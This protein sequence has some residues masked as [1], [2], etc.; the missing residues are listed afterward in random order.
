M[1][2]GGNHLHI[3]CY[4]A[5]AD[6][7]FRSLEGHCWTMRQWCMEEARKGQSFLRKLTM[8]VYWFCVCAR[9]TELT[10]ELP[11]FKWIYRLWR[12]LIAHRLKDIHEPQ[13]ILTAKDQCNFKSH[14]FRHWIGLDPCSVMLEKTVSS[15]H[16][17]VS[18][19]L[20]LRCFYMPPNCPFQGL[21]DLSN[22]KISKNT[23]VY[24]SV[25]LFCVYIHNWPHIWWALMQG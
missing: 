13:L 22:V 8:D 4:F 1:K 3:I 10:W 19:S 14:E 11:L 17:R 20:V 6:F 21:L 15:L 23:L 18:S 7:C 9:A 16:W 12:A 25:C 2:S 24:M 5:C